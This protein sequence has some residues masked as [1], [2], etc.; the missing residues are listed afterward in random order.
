MCSYFRV[1]FLLTKIHIRLNTFLQKIRNIRTFLRMRTFR[2]L[3]N[4]SKVRTQKTRI[5]EHI[6]PPPN[7][8]SDS[9][10]IFFKGNTYDKN[11]N[12]FSCNMR[13]S[14]LVRCCHIVPYFSYNISYSPKMF[15]R[16]P[17]YKNISHLRMYC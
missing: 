12:I 7:V 15:L 10:C 4:V 1:K 2:I 17:G 5:K 13:T 14:L 6:F 3:Q 16:K 9:V 8:I 11:K